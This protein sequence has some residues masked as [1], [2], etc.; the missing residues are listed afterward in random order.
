MR[1]ACLGSG[2][3]GN[4]TLVEAGDV[5]VLV[6]CGFTLKELTRRLA[7]LDVD[8]DSIDAVLVTHEHGD[9]IRGVPVL[10]RKHRPAL[11]MTQGTCSA[12]K[13][14][15]LENLHFVNCHGG[16]FHIGNLRI[17]PYAVPHDAREPSQFVFSDNRVNLG[18][19]TDVGTITPHIVERLGCCDAL[20][21][22]CNHDRRML[23]EGPYPISLQRRVGGDFGHLSNE[24]AA[25]LLERLDRPR[26][27]HLLAAHLSEKNNRPD[28]VRDALLSRA[29]D[30]EQRLRIA[31]Q[32][33]STGWLEV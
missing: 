15:E 33:C 17:E 20:K 26:I 27:R 3:R 8:P 2:S 9:H 30:I 6:D 28:K 23:A 1:F 12:G 24:Q 11:W 21:L 10:S 4:A 7:G 5:R 29:P 31:E 13:C 19:L 32:D 25:D 22:E 18:I 14:S 16:A